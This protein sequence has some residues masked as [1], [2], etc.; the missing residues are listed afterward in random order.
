MR[1]KLAPKQMGGV[2]AEPTVTGEPTDAI[3]G[4]YCDVALL[5]AAE[6]LRIRGGATV[7]CGERTAWHFHRHRGNVERN[8]FDRF[9][10]A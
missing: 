2:K 1:G 6:F 7:V 5:G 10:F 3:R 4:H 8:A 9:G